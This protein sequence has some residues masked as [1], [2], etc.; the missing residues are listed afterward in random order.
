MRYMG[1]VACMG[2][3]VVHRFFSGN[4]NERHN[5][6]DQ[7]IERWTTLKEIFKK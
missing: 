5:L 4:P 3:G 2:K 1:Y 7:G 6:E